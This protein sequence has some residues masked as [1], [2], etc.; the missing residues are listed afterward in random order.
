MVRV[1]IKA[2]L[3]YVCPG[4]SRDF[5][6]ALGQHFVRSGVYGGVAVLL[7]ETAG[8]ILSNCTVCGYCTL[9][10]VEPIIVVL[11]DIGY[12]L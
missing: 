10:T 12:A 8:A 3:Q 4:F 2:A 7:L 9:F 6:S 11:S 1:C 5:R